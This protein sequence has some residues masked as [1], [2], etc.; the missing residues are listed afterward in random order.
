MTHVAALVGGT[1][2]LGTA[3]ATRLAGHGFKLAVTYLVPDQGTAFEDELGLPEDDLFLKRVDATDAEAVT[4]FMKDAAERW[5]QLNVACALVGAWAGGSDVEDTDDVRFD[6]MIDVN[7]RSAFYTVRAA[8]PHLRAAE[9]GR[10]ITIGSRAAF[11]APTGQVAYN[12]AKAGVVSLAQ[13][14]ANELRDS[15]VTANAIVPAVIDTPET[16]EALRWADYMQW[17]TPDDIADVVAFMAGR[18]SGVINGAAIP[19]YG[20]A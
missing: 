7:L 20:K 6:F 5:G 4:A 2:S 1:G 19:V 9:W 14:V 10:I 11:E 18:S 13:T 17:P 16:R 12:A 8:V 3:V 15:N